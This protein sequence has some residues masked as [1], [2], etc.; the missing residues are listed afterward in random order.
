MHSLGQ[1]SPASGCQTTTSKFKPHL[2]VLIEIKF[3]PY[4]S[5]HTI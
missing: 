3:R 5:D 4:G 2:F 1:L